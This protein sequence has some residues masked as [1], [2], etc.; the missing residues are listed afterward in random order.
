MSPM[1]L[2]P[3]AVLIALLA[4]AVAHAADSRPGPEA[5]LHVAPTG[6]DANPG[7]KER[8]FAS[9]A[10]AQAAA[11]Q[12]IA[13]DARENT[14]AVILHA[15]TYFLKEPLAFGPQDTTG[16]RT[17]TYAA[18][19]GENVVVSGGRPITGGHATLLYAGQ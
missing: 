13:A 19:E 18:A 4:A 2:L 5:V 3:T 9:I 1:R 17:V 10:R 16:P 11:R 12:R 7:Q 14:V 15:G 8:P 6:N